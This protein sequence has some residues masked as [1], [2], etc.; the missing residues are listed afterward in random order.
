[1]IEAKWKHYIDACGNNLENCKFNNANNTK[2]NNQLTLRYRFLRAL[3]RMKVSGFIT[4][5]D[6]VEKSPYSTDQVRRCKKLL[7]RRLFEEISKAHF[8]FYVVA[9]TLDIEFPYD[10]VKP[11]HQYFP[12]FFN[13]E[14][15]SAEDFVGLGSISW[16]ECHRAFGG[17]ENH[18]SESYKLLL[19]HSAGRGSQPSGTLELVSKMVQS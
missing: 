17:I 9:L 19:G 4:E 18:F 16:E 5:L 1:M 13:Q 15:G 6:H 2:L 11:S 3:P 14:S 12:L 10:I 8:H 7:P